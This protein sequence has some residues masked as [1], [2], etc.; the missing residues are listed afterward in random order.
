MQFP[1]EIHLG[2]FQLSLHVIMETLAFMVG[3]RYFL[4][5]RKKQPDTIT[6]INRLWIIVG[7]TFGAFFFSRL[8]GSLED[9]VAFYQSTHPFL[10]FFANKTILGGLLGGLFMVEGTK[11]IIG[12]TSSSGDLFTYPLILAMIIGRIGC[13]G[14]GVHESTY[15]IETTF[16]TGMNLGDGL[17]RHPVALYE[18]GFLVLLWIGLVNLEKFIKL[19]SGYRFQL[20]L[21][22]YL[23]FRFGIDFIKPGLKYFLGLGTIQIC[24]ILGLIYYS[25]TIFKIIFTP[26]TIK[27]SE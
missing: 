17:Y 5:L 20:F 7:A 11:K 6:E 18:I 10:Y 22:G 21:I 8:V 4:Y 1:V 26:S 3:F 16:F 27:A 24:C 2:N 14:N 12:E 25:N 19:R 23:L 15:G 13:F 9:P